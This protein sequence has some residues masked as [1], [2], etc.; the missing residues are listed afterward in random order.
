MKLLRRKSAELSE[1]MQI[2]GRLRS[3]Q[4]SWYRMGKA[5]AQMK[6]ADLRDGKRKT[7]S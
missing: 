5:K 2:L 4:L 1:K 3:R 7:K 6:K